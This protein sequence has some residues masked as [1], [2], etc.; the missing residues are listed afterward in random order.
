MLLEKN[1]KLNNKILKI[2]YLYILGVVFLQAMT[3]IFLK[4]AALS[5]ESYSLLSILTNVLYLI[6][7]FLFFGRAVFWMQALKHVPLGLAYTVRSLGYIILLCVSY[8]Y[9]NETIT[10]MNVFGCGLIVFGIIL[11]VYK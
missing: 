3:N 10:L 2:G 11:S 9:F 7:L 4:S 8:F 5:M 6:S 1:M